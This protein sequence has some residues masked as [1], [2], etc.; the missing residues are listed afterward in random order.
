MRGSPGAA[1]SQSMTVR[2]FSGSSGEGLLRF[3]ISNFVHLVFV[4]TKRKNM[5]AFDHNPSVTFCSIK[6]ARQRGIVAVTM[7]FT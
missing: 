3:P 6:I 2:P 4:S 5:H 7:T 1:S